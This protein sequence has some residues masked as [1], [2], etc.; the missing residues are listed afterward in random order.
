VSHEEVR[1][2]VER[3]YPRPGRVDVVLVRERKQVRRLAPDRFEESQVLLRR[4]FPQR[5]IDLIGD[6]ELRMGEVARFAEAGEWGAHVAVEPQRDGSVRVRLMERTLTDAGI[7]V[8][9]RA[10]RTF[11]ATDPDALVHAAEIAEELREWAAQRNEALA[12]EQADG[13]LAEADRE[14]D[15]AER[16]RLALELARIVDATA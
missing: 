10:D 8:E 14:S 1:F 9:V 4:T 6:C 5:R 15:Q 16:E 11:D 3:R 7:R 2:A 13:E 12:A